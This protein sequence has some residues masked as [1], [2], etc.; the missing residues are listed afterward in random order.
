MP[1]KQVVDPLIVND[2][3]VGAK[4]LAGIDYNESINI[5]INNAVNP[6]TE[7][8]VI[9]KVHRTIKAAFKKAGWEEYQAN[10]ILRP[11]IAF[12]TFAQATKVQDLP[13]HARAACLVFI[14]EAQKKQEE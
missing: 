14:K 3:V 10:E 5:K 13:A 9:N 1:K 11:C 8:E 12:A 7:R 2:I 6:K 4:S